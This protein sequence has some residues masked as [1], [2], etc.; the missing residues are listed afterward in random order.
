[1]KKTASTPSSSIC[2][3]AVSVP[4]RKLFDYLIPETIDKNCLQAGMR[5]MVPFGRQKRN[6]MI[7]DPCVT[8]TIDHARLKP[9]QSLIDTQPLFQQH[10]MQLLKWA[11]DYYHH[12]IG[13]VIHAALP[14]LLRK[15]H[16]AE[17]PTQ[18]FL[19]LTQQGKTIDLELL[20]RAPRQQQ[21][22]AHLQSTSDNQRST[23]QLSAQ[24]ITWRQC[25]PALIKK[26][27]IEQHTRVAES[28]PSQTSWSPPLAL[29]KAQQTAVNTVTENSGQFGVFLLDGVTGSGKT[30]VY[31]QL[32]QQCLNQ[33]QQVLVLLPE[34]A[35]TPQLEERFCSRFPVPIGVYH[36]GLSD[37]LRCAHWLRFQRGMT[38]ILLGTRSATFI[39]M[40]RP[41]LIIM[42]EEHDPSF[43]QQEGFRFSARN[44]AIR[45]AQLLDIPILLG[46]ATP[47]IETIYN[48]QT[49]RYRHLKL[50]ARAGK[51]VLPELKLLDIRNRKMQSGLSEPLIQHIDKTLS[52]NEQVML[53]INRRGYAPAYMCH[54]CGWVARC[55]RCDAN[56]VVHIND[57][58]LWCHHCGSNSILPQHCLACNG[59]KVEA[60]GVGTERVEKMLQEQ[61]PDV[62]IARFDRDTVRTKATLDAMLSA[63]QND[64]IDILIGTQ[65]LAKGHHFPN[66]TLVCILDTDQGL[67]ST[68]F[69]AA[70]RLAQM[71]IQVAGRSGRADKIGQVILQTRQP[72]HPLLLTLIRQD[73]AQFALNCIQ[74]RQQADLPPL[75]HQILFRAKAANP[76]A[77][78][79]LLKQLRIELEKITDTILI[80]GPVPAPME[81]LA[82]QYRYQLLLQ[83][84]HRREL[85]QC[86]DRIIPYIDTLK[87]NKQA[88]WS[89][90]V[91][92]I[93]LY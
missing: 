57:Q 86:L 67:F 93:D 33:Q 42:D 61:F 58:R 63:V 60:L 71:I 41:G 76:A 39:P 82:G 53:F 62:K 78:M 28:V 75:T 70:E 14:G 74:E 8:S 9:L 66:V 21:L 73:Y 24:D 35:L 19:C 26:Q 27:L 77:P 81:K 45:R 1:M 85:H 16:A 25:L 38:P 48:A 49:Q 12:P 68:D 50:P 65:M 29:T 10:D 22:I 88:R 15:S 5:V 3:V 59:T 87:E 51:A 47:A 46:T 37:K 7:I 13:E 31:M 30:E 80:L 36:S 34:I 92:P 40:L 72:E 55:P 17:L 64:E 44:V 4:L 11:A 84:Q 20:K 90:D 2:R 43:K 54:Q 56:A 83:S 32:I 89:V 6:A 52:R 23:D 18:T 91:D 69:R 79:A